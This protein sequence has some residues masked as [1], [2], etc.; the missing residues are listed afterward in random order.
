MLYLF[1]LFLW[2]EAFLYEF[3]CDLYGIG[4]STLAKVVSYA[5]EVESVLH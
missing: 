1:L 3:L 2:K 5:P 4:C